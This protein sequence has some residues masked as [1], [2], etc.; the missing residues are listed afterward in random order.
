LAKSYPS[1]IEV[2]N[3]QVDSLKDYESPIT[4]HYD[5][6]LNTNKADVLYVNPLLNDA[7]QSNPFSAADRFFPIE[8]DYKTNHVYTLNLEVPKGYIID[9]IPKSTRV[10]LDDKNSGIFEY[11]TA[12]NGSNIQLRSK[13]ILNKALF[14]ADDYQN[15]RNFFVL[16]VKKHAEQIVFRKIKQ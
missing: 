11:L 3:L 16:V 10:K 7:I 6:K 8:M 9:E 4:L 5:L 2:S 12:V 14:S 13:L 15:L 1:D